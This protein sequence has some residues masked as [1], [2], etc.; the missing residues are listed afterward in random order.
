MRR[1]QRHC[2]LWTRSTL[3]CVT[4]S[5]MVWYWPFS[6]TSSSSSEPK[7]PARQDRKRCWESR[8]A[9]HACLDAAG[10][11]KPGDEGSACEKQREAYEKNC[12]ESWVC[13]LLL[14]LFV[15]LLIAVHRSSISMKE[16]CWRSSRR[17]RWLWRTHRQK[18]LVGKEDDCILLC[19]FSIV[20]SLHSTQ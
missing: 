8:D 2:G 14:L 3:G 19:S 1:S 12:A 11:V 9:Y 17:N 15:V 10:I 4:R 6:S 13:V 16:E 18:K 20:Y 5:A 7:P